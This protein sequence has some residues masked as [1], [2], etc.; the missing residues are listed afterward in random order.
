M[1]P[2]TSV[3]L[4]GRLGFII[5][6]LHHHVWTM[7]MWGRYLDSV[8]LN[9]IAAIQNNLFQTSRLCFVIRAT[10]VYLN[11]PSKCVFVYLSEQTNSISGQVAQSHAAVWW[12]R[13]EEE[14]IA[15]ATRLQ[16]SH[17]VKMWL[18]TMQEFWRFFVYSVNWLIAIVLKDRGAKQATFY[19]DK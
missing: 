8:V 1:L 5:G 13:E 11:D 16:V 10:A 7:R 6:S 18:D 19:V 2:P 3:L 17:S 12:C 15:L 9:N 4:C 14:T